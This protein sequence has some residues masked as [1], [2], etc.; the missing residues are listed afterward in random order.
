MGMYRN[1]FNLEI[2]RGIWADFSRP[3]TPLSSLFENCDIG[4]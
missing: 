1:L 2:K 4:W 3:N